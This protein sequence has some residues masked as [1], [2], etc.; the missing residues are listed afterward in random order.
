M[1]LIIALDKLSDYN[2]QYVKEVEQIL[3][4][5]VANDLRMLFAGITARQQNIPKWDFIE[6]TSITAIEEDVEIIAE[7]IRQAHEVLAE[8]IRFADQI[9][10]AYPVNRPFYHGT[11]RVVHRIKRHVIKNVASGVV[12][13]IA[14]IVVLI[15]V[16]LWGRW[17][18]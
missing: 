3:L 17:T 16:Y 7:I 2:A 9:R 6:M 8:Q 1:C 12:R 18:R 13:I 5:Q 15:L 10:Q 11:R 4:G 14:S